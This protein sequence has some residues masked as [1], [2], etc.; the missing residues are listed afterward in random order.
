MTIL[1]T[2][3][4]R[5][6][7]PEIHNFTNSIWIGPKREKADGAFLWLFAFFS[8]S[9][10]CIGSLGSFARDL[11]P[12]I[13]FFP[14]FGSLFLIPIIWGRLTRPFRIDFNETAVTLIYW[15]RKTVIQNDDVAEIRF[16]RK[17]INQQYKGRTITHEQYQLLIDLENGTTLMIPQGI[18]SESWFHLI[19]KFEAH[20]KN[21]F[22]RN[23]TETYVP[24]SQFS[25]GA[26]KKW[27]LYLNDDTAVTVNSLAEIQ[28]WLSSCKYMLD[29]DQFGKVEHWV[30]P[31]EFEKTKLGDCEDHALWAWHKLYQLNIPAEFVVGTNDNGNGKW[32]GHAWVMLK[33]SGL[34]HVLEATNKNGRMFVPWEDVKNRYK[35]RVGVNHDL[36]TFEYRKYP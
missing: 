20:P 27:S 6:F 23:K 25:S 26:G 2:I 22:Y 13:L 32:V 28:S 24:Y 8:F 18:S 11:L 35:L 12:I 30:T 29:Q 34:L 10:I 7:P 17:L 16:E 33:I 21:I 5:V 31:S 15:N 1:R 4:A 14:A 36:K 19:E 9:G 3:Y